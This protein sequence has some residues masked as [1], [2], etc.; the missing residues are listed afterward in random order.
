[1]TQLGFRLT[2]PPTSRAAAESAGQLRA[3]HH[4]KILAFLETQGSIGATYREAALAT[5]LE[6]VQ[7]GRRMGELVALG[8]AKVVGERKLSTGRVGRIFVKVGA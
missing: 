4:A 8:K 6:P 5:G 7:V 2:D 3:E 1:M